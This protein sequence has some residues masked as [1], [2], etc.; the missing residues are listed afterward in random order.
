MVSSRRTS[1]ASELRTHPHHPAAGAT[2]AA[3]VAAATITH[4]L[5][6]DVITEVLDE[7]L[8]GLRELVLQQLEVLGATLAQVREVVQEE[9]E[10]GLAVLLVLHRVQ[11]VGVPRLVDLLRRH[12]RTLG[13]HHAQLQELAVE[14]DDLVGLL[15]GHGR[16][17]RLGMNELEGDRLEVELIDTPELLLL[18]HQLCGHSILLDKGHL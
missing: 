18:G 5:V 4:R 7:Q 17:S 8:T 6:D 14:T 2:H 1:A 3:A 11:D 13:V 15:H 10:D 12:D 9:A 16:L